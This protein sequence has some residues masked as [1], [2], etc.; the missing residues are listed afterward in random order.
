MFHYL[1]W[2]V[3]GNISCS[4]SF[5]SAFCVIARKFGC[6]FWIYENRR[7]RLCNFEEKQNWEGAHKKCTGICVFNFV[8]KT[9]GHLFSLS[10]LDLSVKIC[11][12]KPE[13]G[14]SCKIHAK[15]ERGKSCKIHAK[16]ER[17]K[18]CKIH[19]KLAFPHLQKLFFYTCFAEPS[20]EGIYKRELFITIFQVH[21]LSQRKLIFRDITWNVSVKNEILRGIFNKEPRPSRRVRS[22]WETKAYE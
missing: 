3:A 11:N 13:W 15:P 21:T 18:S 7:P 14:K 20:M 1:T 19:A 2:N 6:R 10:L 16:P 17:G 5:S 9:V 12:A 8:D 4:I 22:F